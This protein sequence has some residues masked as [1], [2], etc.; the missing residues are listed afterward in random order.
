VLVLEAAPGDSDVT[1]ELLLSRGG[2]GVGPFGPVV[3]AS[4]PI[5]C[6]DDPATMTTGET[7]SNDEETIGVGCAGF[8]GA[9]A[10][11]ASEGLSE[12]ASPGDVCE[13]WID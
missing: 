13:G 6:V 5:V 1:N 7:E 2:V 9:D 4:S 8:P 10:L 11:T 12:L 3:T